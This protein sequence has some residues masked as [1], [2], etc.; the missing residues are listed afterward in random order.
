MADSLN[1]KFGEKGLRFASEWY[2]ERG[3][4]DLA[5]SCSPC[6]DWNH[7]RAL[8]HGAEVPLLTAI[9]DCILAGINSKEIV[10]GESRIESATGG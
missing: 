2:C 4:P 3:L 10:E 6:P 7:Q 1:M 5:A 9:V 8:G